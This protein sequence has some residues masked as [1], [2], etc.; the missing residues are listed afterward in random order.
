MYQIASVK[1]VSKAT[2]SVTF[3]D[4]VQ[5]TIDLSDLLLKGTARDLLDPKRFKTVRVD[6]GGGIE[7]DNGYD[8][9]PTVIRER[10]MQT[11]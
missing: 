11:H 5:S 8:I 2:I 3:T 9:C 7:W 6:S 10:A 1:A 4:G